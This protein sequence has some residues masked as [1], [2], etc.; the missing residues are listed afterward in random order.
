[1]TLLIL[2]LTTLLSCSNILEH[3]NE[4]H[5]M[6][7]GKEEKDEQQG[8]QA[9]LLQNISLTKGSQNLMMDRKTQDQHPFKIPHFKTEEQRMPSFKIQTKFPPTWILV[10][11]CVL[12]INYLHEN[13][14]V[15]KQKQRK[16]LFMSKEQSLLR[17]GIL[18]IFKQSILLHES[19]NSKQEDCTPAEC[20]GAGGAAETAWAYAAAVFFGLEK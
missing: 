1:M 8:L 9:T 15:T 12:M 5:K 19:D 2:M 3:L 16:L 10:S 4:V 14:Q 18:F 17:V 7:G 6:D 20:G 13:C 11:S